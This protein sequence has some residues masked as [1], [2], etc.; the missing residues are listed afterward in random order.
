[1]TTATSSQSTSSNREHFYPRVS[2]LLTDANLDGFVMPKTDGHKSEYCPDEANLML[3]FT[4]FSG[5]MGACAFLNHEQSGA[6]CVD[7]RYTLQAGQE[8]DV[9]RFEIIDYKVSTIAQWIAAGTN[10]TKE[11][12][13]RIGFDPDLLSLFEYSLYAKQFAAHNLELVAM[14]QNPITKAWLDRPQPEIYK[15]FD[16]DISYAGVSREQKLK[17]IQD[18]MSSEGA[19]QI[20]LNYPETIFWLFN[21]RAHDKLMTPVAPMYAIINRQGKHTLFCDARQN[22]DLIAIL[23]DLVDLQPY[24]DAFSSH[25]LFAGKTVALDT[26]NAT[27]KM[28]DLVVSQGGSPL[29]TQDYGEMMRAIKNNVEQEGARNAHVR[30]GA[31]ICNL[32]AWLEKSIQTDTITELDVVAKLWLY[33]QEQD[34]IKGYSFDTISGSGP[35]GAIVHYRVDDQSNRT[36]NRNDIF[37]LDSGGQYLDGTTDITRTI[38]LDKSPTPEQKD[39][40]TRVL[41]GHIAISTLKFPKHTTGSQ[42]DAIAR[43]YLWSIGAN[44]DHGTGHGVGSYLGVHEGPQKISP[45]LN[46]TPLMPGMIV[47]NEPGYYKTGEYGIRIENLELITACERNE[48][49]DDREMYKLET[50]TLA[51]IDTSLIEKDLLSESEIQWLNGYHKR[52]YAAL[53][54]RVQ[55]HAQ[56]WLRD[57]TQPI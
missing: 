28:R 33:R 27:I 36:L 15:L 7:G 20:F 9:T 30:D 19:D 44:Y 6:V 24:E 56:Q 54:N 18:R 57:A 42:I 17:L 41:K 14:A 1:M 37:L 47:S 25:T 4:G 26:T 22:Q 53:S 52:V 16:H 8:V 5:S 21:I 49:V 46:Q 34:L 55:A 29:E 50:L 10:S 13:A 38:S 12:P 11:N 48:C 51:P 45:A 23:G 35:N 43:Q 39:R 32:L 2:Q 3:A 31:A 40:F